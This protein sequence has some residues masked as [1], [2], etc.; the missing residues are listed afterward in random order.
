M[1]GLRSAANPLFQ[2]ASRVFRD[3]A[4]A[5]VLTGNGS[6]GSEGILAISTMGESSSPR[7]LRRPNTSECRSPQLTRASLTTCFRWTRL[8]PRLSKSSTVV[9]RRRRR[10]S[11][12][13]S[14]Y[15]CALLFPTARPYDLT[16]E[17]LPDGTVPTWIRL[18]RLTT[19]VN[20]RSHRTCLRGRTV[21]EHSHCCNRGV[22]DLLMTRPILSPRIG[23]KTFE[24]L[25]DSRQRPARWR[26][27][28]VAPG[29]RH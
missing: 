24:T 28:Q 4:I 19:G 20:W 16:I 6:D 25:R 21:S 17:P 22:R 7:T 15:R 3:R 1:H 23:P 2:S 27:L 18:G 26:V 14:G 12:L 11:R 13:N 29:D 8:R 5:V 10:R 9:Y